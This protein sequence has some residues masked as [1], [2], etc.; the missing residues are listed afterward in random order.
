MTTQS[1]TLTPEQQA[2]LKLVA[3]F[4]KALLPAKLAGTHENG[5]TLAIEMNKRALPHTI[6][7]MVRVTN[8]ILFEDKLTWTIPPAKLAARSKNERPITLQ[9]PR[10]VEAEFV[11]KVRAG[12]AVDSKKAADAA[13]IKQAKDLIAAYNPVR[14]NRFDAREQ[15]DAQKHWSEALDKAIADKANLQQFAIALAAA[16]QNRYATRE[17]ASERM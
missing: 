3:D 12:E 6:E 1:A 9:S 4:Q 8:E 7:N 14:N 2:V 5:A 16:I 11:A 15:M 17:R 10:E 13:S